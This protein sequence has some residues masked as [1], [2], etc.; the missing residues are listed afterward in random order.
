MTTLYPYKIDVAALF[1]EYGG[2]AELHRKLDR[3]GCTAQKKTVQKWHER[4]S[5][6]TDALVTLM[7]ARN[8]RVP[9]LVKLRRGRRC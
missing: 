9:H 5:I 4:G 7:A 1:E 8:L 3:L 2:P 6:P